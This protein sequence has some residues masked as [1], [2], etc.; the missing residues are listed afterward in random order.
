LSRNGALRYNGNPLMRSHLIQPSMKPKF[1]LA[2]PL[3]AMLAA[4]LAAAGPVH[5][6]PQQEGGQVSHQAQATQPGE[7]G[8]PEDLIRLGEA[9]L[10]R[11][12]AVEARTLFEEAL[13]ERPD[14]VRALLGLG[15]ALAA[16]RRY[17]EA[18]A[19]YV[20]MEA[21]RLDP[22]AAH[23]GRARLRALQGDHEGAKQ[24]YKDVLQ[25]DPRNLEARLGLAREAHAPGLERTAL[26]QADNLVLD[27]PESEEA[28]TLQR[29]VHN[30]LRPR[31]EADAAATSDDGG[32]RTR[33]W[34]VA[35]VFMPVPQSAVRVSFTAHEA[36][37]NGSASTDARLLSA[38]WTSRL[39][40]PLA[41]HARIGA[42]QEERLDQGE[43][44][45]LIGDGN[46]RWE[47]EPHFTMHAFASRRA[48]LDSVP[49]IDWG[50]RVDTGEMRL[51]YRR[52]PA[53]TLTADGELSRYSDGNARETAAAGVVW[54][55]T[56]LRPRVTGTLEVRLRRFH[57]DRDF[58][59]L[60]PIH[61]DSERVTVTLSD[62]LAEGRFTWSL[63]GTYGWQ[64][65]DDND[66]ERVPVGPPDSPLRGGAASIGAR[67][68]ERCT[69]EAFHRRTN[70]ALA[71]AP[72]F[73]VRKSGFTLT[74]RL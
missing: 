12:D 39:I 74:I 60:D 42:A 25:A 46:V 27:H 1:A 73:P 70:D 72:G 5:A 43:R 44:V 69:L 71:S 31:L 33:A 49:L 40:R 36:T 30:A 34:E 8:S 56:G 58:G 10:E 11:G 52:H 24:L 20:D 62:A 53:I 16:R 13:R 14:D 7:A 26:A 9:C 63:E 23:L 18:E 4:C 61:Y 6:R 59:Y 35:S 65:Y 38:A 22:L 67:L 32:N 21:R 48:L 55:P 2:A 15:R 47:I 37:L 64:D 29:E 45:V 19:V 66:F 68:G 57:D 17:V 54:A 51:E 41:F 3:A 28:R 50:I